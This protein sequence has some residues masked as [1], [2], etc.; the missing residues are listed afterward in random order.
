MENE[1]P[2]ITKMVTV[3][4]VLN[5]SQKHNPLAPFSKGDFGI[6]ESPFSKGDLEALNPLLL[7]GTLEALNPR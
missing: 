3:Q 4:P 7:R 2:V 1:Y 6:A 5:R